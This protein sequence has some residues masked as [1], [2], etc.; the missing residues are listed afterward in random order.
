[1]GMGKYKDVRLPQD[2]EL[3]PCPF[4]GGFDG[5]DNY[6]PLII[7]HSERQEYWVECDACGASTAEGQDVSD[8]IAR[9]NTRICNLP[10]E[11]TN[12]PGDYCEGCDK[13]VGTP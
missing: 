7:Y 11:N 10:T 12:C 9:W 1:M 3:L 6:R 5:Q 2:R 13:C 8:V 4:C